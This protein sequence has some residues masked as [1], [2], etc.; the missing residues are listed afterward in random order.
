[1]SDNAVVA[2]TLHEIAR[3]ASVGEPVIHPAARIAE[4]SGD[5]WVECA[6]S[7]TPTLLFQIPQAVL[8]DVDQVQWDW[9]GNDLELSPSAGADARQVELLDA[10]RRLYNATSK[11]LWFKN[12][13]PRAVLAMHPGIAEAVQ[14][15]KPTVTPDDSAASFINTRVLR[16]PGIGEHTDRA[17]T[18]VLMP[19][20]DAL[21]NHPAG[22]HFV[23]RETLNVALVQPTASDECFAFYGH[24][25]SDPLAIALAYGYEEIHAAVA[26]SG[27]VSVTVPGLGRVDVASEPPR[28]DS[29]LDPPRITV[30]DDGVSLSHLTFQRDQPQRLHVP[31]QMF[32]QTLGMSM[33]AAGRTADYLI[34]AVGD[35]NLELLANLR[36]TIDTAPTESASPALTMLSAASMRQAAIIEASC[37]RP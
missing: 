27:P 25:R 30:H 14:K 7:S 12:H 24:R 9:S 35:A 31:V 11:G 5:M 10:H 33:A 17:A 29:Q 26:V 22:A 28:R 2:A 8:P 16:R 23:G 18:R 19:L 34:G 20:I 32:L 1:M 6:R 15:L 13:H 36:R 21:N 37:T 3:M 4:S